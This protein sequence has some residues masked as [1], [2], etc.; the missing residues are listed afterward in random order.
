M[1]RAA[2]GAATATA[3]GRARGRRAA[4]ECA[5]YVYRQSVYTE[6]AREVGGEKAEKTAKAEKAEKAG[7]E[8]SGARAAAGAG[9]RSYLTYRYERTTLPTPPPTTTTPTTTTYYCRCCD[10]HYYYLTLITVQRHG[11]AAVW[12]LVGQASW[13]SRADLHSTTTTVGKKRHSPSQTLACASASVGPQGS[14]RLVNR[15]Y[16]NS[17]PATTS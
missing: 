12:L 13:N 5:R 6:R 4:A 11:M 2:V 1:V 7:R 10:D 8:Q 17:L 16:T 14:P 9:L 3:S 15:S